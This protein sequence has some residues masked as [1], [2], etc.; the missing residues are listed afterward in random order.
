MLFRSRVDMAESE[1]TLVESPFPN[2]S[3]MAEST[4]PN[5]RILDRVTLAESENTW[6]SH[7][8]RIREYLAESP[9]PNSRILGRVTLA[10]SESFG[11]GI[12]LGCCGQKP[13]LP[14]GLIWS[15]V[16]PMPRHM[17]AMA[18]QLAWCEQIVSSFLR[19]DWI[20]SKF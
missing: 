2:P 14:I 10:E 17:P 13:R 5:P 15:V 3:G 19:V 8:G 1:N 4:W 16:R 11:L 6:P 18:R 9:W 12:C 20:F 7:L